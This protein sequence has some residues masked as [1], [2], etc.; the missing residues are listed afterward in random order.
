MPDPPSEDKLK[1]PDFLFNHRYPPQSAGTLAGYLA[2]SRVARC[3]DVDLMGHTDDCITCPYIR[4]PC[5]VLTGMVLVSNSS[6]EKTFAIQGAVVS[7]LMLAKKK[8]SF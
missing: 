3:R 2:T 7:K 6:P 1:S 8:Y 4:F 5:F